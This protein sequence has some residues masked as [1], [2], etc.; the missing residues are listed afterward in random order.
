[1]SHLWGC[2]G[3]KEKDETRPE[4]IQACVVDRHYAKGK[5]SYIYP[6]TK[7]RM[8]LWFSFVVFVVSVAALLVCTAFVFR[9][10]VWLFFSARLSNPLTPCIDQSQSFIKLLY[11][12][13]S[14]TDRAMNL[15]PIVIQ[16][17]VI[18][19]FERYYMI[20]EALTELENY[21]TVKEHNTA[22]FRKISVFSFISSYAALTYIAFFK[23]LPFRRFQRSTKVHA[24]IPQYHEC[25]SVSSENLP[26]SRVR[27]IPPVA[28]IR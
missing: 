5:V 20:A 18:T 4:Y 13:G 22:L 25:A 9:L 17:L 26:L 3:F 27:W 2:L 11:P 14:S 19:F 23:V 16:S 1:M 8:A 21:P 10:K 24:L 28:K 7:R 6:E 15:I 12:G